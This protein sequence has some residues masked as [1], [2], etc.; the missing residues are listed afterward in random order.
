MPNLNEFIKEKEKSFNSIC[1]TWCPPD[2]RDEMKKYGGQ[3]IKDALCQAAELTIAAGK[4]EGGKE[5]L[6]MVLG[7][8]ARLDIY[9]ESRGVSVNKAELIANLL[10]LSENKPK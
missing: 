3:F 9:E 2:W 6:A 1:E 4:A 5:M 8:I 7:T 10:S